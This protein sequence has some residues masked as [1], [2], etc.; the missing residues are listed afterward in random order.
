MSKLQSKIKQ[1]IGTIDELYKIIR[2]IKSKD[3]YYN[4]WY[5]ERLKVIETFKKNSDLL[6][7]I[8][9][10]KEKLIIKIMKKTLKEE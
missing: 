8:N 2:E 7:E 3:H 1:N 4:L 10:L 9:S 6:D 5:K